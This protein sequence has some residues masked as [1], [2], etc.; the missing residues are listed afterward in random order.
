[1]SSPTPGELGSSS[2]GGFRV[3]T[4][5]G[6]A[7]RLHASVLLIFGLIVYSLATGLLPSWHEDWGVALRWGVAFGAGLL[8]F[9]SLLIHELAHT[10]VARSY[11]ISVPRITLFLFGGISEMKDDPESPRQELFV[12]IAGPI[13]SLLLGIGFSALALLLVGVHA[14]A[15]LLSDPY[16]TIP[17]LGAWPTLLLWLGPVNTLLGLF[18]LIPAFPMDGGR[19]LR[20]ALWAGTGKLEKATRWASELGA[21][22]GWTL[23][24]LGVLQLFGGNLAGLWLVL[25]GWFL[26]HTAQASYRQLRL[27]NLLEERRAEDLMRTR[28]ESVPPELPLPTFIEER[29]LRSGQR[30]WPVEEDGRNVGLI[31]VERAREVPEEERSAL[32]VRDVM[33][34]TR[35]LCTIPADLGGR[36]VLDALRAED[37]DPL[38][39]T[40]SGRIVGFLRPSDVQRWLALQGSAAA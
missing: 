2:R 9:V 37:G 25:I 40:R 24:G 14:R 8:F 18:N 35:E 22:F 31:T 11:G 13:A 7:I 29:L 6:V 16:A 17:T 4:L 20:A 12:A 15:G 28:Y 34:E 27:R 3:G 30:W 23:L 5:A 19:V 1:M 36:E 38:P 39:V 21:I 33:A 26:K 32:T 10:F